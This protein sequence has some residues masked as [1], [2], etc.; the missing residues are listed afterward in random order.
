MGSL[1]IVFIETRID[2]IFWM[3]GHHS[4]GAQV[5]ARSGGN[6]LKKYVP[7]CYFAVIGWNSTDHG[8]K[9]IS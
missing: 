6:S 3:R 8:F 4:T 9:V 5:S 2:L 7:Y 1:E